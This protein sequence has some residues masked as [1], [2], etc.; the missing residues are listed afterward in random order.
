MNKIVNLKIDKNRSLVLQIIRHQL[1]PEQEFP[2]KLFT[3]LP[4]ILFDCF[5]E[6]IKSRA[7]L[8]ELYQQT[9]DKAEIEDLA[10]K[11]L[12]FENLLAHHP[13]TVVLMYRTY[14]KKFVRYKNAAD[15]TTS[16]EW[17]DI[18]QEVIT[19]LIS[20]KIQRIQERFDFTYK[21]Y[22]NFS[23]KNLFTS[24]LMVTVRNI[25]MDIIRERKVRLL[26][27]G[28]TLPIDEVIERYNFKGENLMNR[29]V[30]DQEFEKLHT[31]L[32][33]YYKSRPRLELCLKLKCRILL[34]AED[35]KDCFPGCS[36]EDINIL[37]QDFKGVKDKKLFDT[38]VPAFNRNEGRLNKSDTLRKWIS[39][40]LDEI[41]SHLNQTHT[42]NVYNSKNLVD[43][44]TLYYEQFKVNETDTAESLEW[45]GIRSK[46]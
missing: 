30:I 5:M 24:Y 27:R 40:K 11:I 28:Q 31:V 20:G 32:A 38:V 16:D 33:L 43:L 7:D 22:N 10:R 14:I 13:L 29:L 36:S 42:D 17:E 8:M 35:I 19:R 15:N 26:T 41:T 34:S 46:V 23:K 21:K 6:V 9:D 3:G 39:V 25:Y 37:R 4:S 45:L 2:E 18:F 1:Y 44:I 12:E